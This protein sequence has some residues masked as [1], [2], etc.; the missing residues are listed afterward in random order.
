M[1]ER[2]DKHVGSDIARAR[3]QDDDKYDDSHLHHTDSGIQDVL[4]L[5]TNYH[6]NLDTVLINKLA[7]KLHIKENKSNPQDKSNN[8]ER[9]IS[10]IMPCEFTDN[11][12]IL[13]G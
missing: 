9:A 2:L 3:P 1:S 8:V 5:P 7:T 11:V 6:Q 4:L 10:S 13:N 12:D